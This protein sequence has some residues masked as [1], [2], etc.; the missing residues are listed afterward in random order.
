MARSESSARG[1]KASRA[2]GKTVS[3]PKSAK[4]APAAGGKTPRRGGAAK[5]IPVHV[6]SHTHWDRAWYSPFQI[7]R[8]RLI[9]LVDHLVRLLESEPEYKSFFFDGQIVPIEDYLEARPDRRPV[10]ERLAREGRLRLGPHYI[11][12]DEFLI[13]GESLIRNLLVGTLETARFAPPERVGYIPDPFG[14]VSQLPQILNGFGIDSFFFTRGMNARTWKLGEEFLWKGADGESRVLAIHQWRGYGNAM[15]LGHE[16]FDLKFKPFEAKRAI[17]RAERLVAEMLPRTPSGTLLFCNGHDHMPAQAT[18]PQAIRAI[19]AAARGRYRLRHSTFTEYLRE[20]RKSGAKHGEYQGEL[21]GIHQHWILSG[22]YSARL[23][24]KQANAQCQTLLERYTEPLASVMAWEGEPYPADALRLAWKTLLK[25]HPHDDICGCSVDETHR[26]MVPRFAHVRQMGGWLRD[27]ALDRLLFQI[28]MP[29]AEA[30]T[31]LLVFNPLAWE[32]SAGVRAILDMPAED[33]ADEKA[34]ELL[35][36]QGRAVA[37]SFARQG[38]PFERDWARGAQKRQM[39]R[40]EF[41]ADRLPAGGY[42]VFL[43]RRRGADA[44]EPQTAAE[45]PLRS[46]PRGMENEFL[47]LEIR[48]DGSLWIF[49]KATGA[50]LGRTH[51]FEDRGDRGDE[52]DFDPL[53]EEPPLYSEGTGLTWTIAQ[54]APDRLTASAQMDFLVPAGLEPD[55]ARRSLARVTLPLRTDITIRPGSR[56]VD[57]RVT[58]V[59]HARDH[60][61]RVGVEIPG[62]AGQVWV[63]SKFDVLKRGFGAPP[64]ARL[65]VQDPKPTAPQNDWAALE[66][67]GRGV[68]VFNC[69]LPEYEA[70]RAPGLTRYWLTILRSVGWLSRGDMATRPGNAGPELPAPEAQCL[71]EQHAEFSL[72]FYEGGWQAAA[73]ARAA[74]EYLTPPLAAG[75]SHAHRAA[76]GSHALPTRHSFYSVEPQDLIVSAVKQAEADPA[77]RILR[78]WNPGGRARQ[79]V[80]TLDRPLASARRVRLDETPLETLNPDR[81][82]PNRVVVEVKPKEIVT[83]ELIPR[84]G[85]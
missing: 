35:D 23:Y 71:G 4:K 51:F 73:I 28:A 58:F 64:R 32:R 27:R 60:R 68:A 9:E 77:A 39:V 62:E 1:K 78:L 40:V 54:R 37:A 66:C 67:E 59:N 25:N 48:E 55:R 10:I 82:H 24:L 12:P 49:D 14:H 3:R 38:E 84:A 45:S 8:L 65:D 17:E 13:S 80:I 30:G 42:E 79:A 16:M 5:P 6:V 34:L 70:E 46:F 53:A 11:L 63:E 26:D 36:S 56:R 20:V 41:L 19:N 15:A 75:F 29:P 61:L 33:A 31:P 43:A 81:A 50:P 57:F 22:V 18:L 47:R 2:S 7:F 52:Y 85:A 21:L 72:F 76:M 83:V 44:P 69:G 74:Q